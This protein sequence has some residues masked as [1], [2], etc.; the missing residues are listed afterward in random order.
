MKWVLLILAC[1]LGLILCL[2]V[3]VRISLQQGVFSAFVLAGPKQ[4]QVYPFP[5]K[6]K[7]RKAEK[8]PREQSAKPK[9]KRAGSS[10]SLETLCQYAKLGLSALGAVLRGLRVDLLRCYAVIHCEE[11]A[12][13]TAIQYGAACAAVT[14]VL[15]MM[16]QV[17]N[18]QEKDIQVDAGFQGQGS[19]L[20]DLRITAAIG[21]L[22]AIGFVYAVKFILLQRKVKKNEQSQRNDA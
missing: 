18:I 2:R 21:R 19:L 15:P 7:P 17:L 11:D 6:E 3:G 12:A 10:P 5:K 4:I 13:Q 8:K 22:V 14:A 9:E 16:E 1:L 20:L